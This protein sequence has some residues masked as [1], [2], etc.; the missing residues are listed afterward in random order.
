MIY[1]NLSEYL[2]KHLVHMQQLMML[3]TNSSEDAGFRSI[4]R[5]F[6]KF[7]KKKSLWCD[8]KPKK[9]EKKVESNQKVFRNKSEAIYEKQSLIDWT[10][11]KN[12]K[13]WTVTAT[14]R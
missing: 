13:L 9:R 14:S 5:K 11:K 8:L 10:K 1:N 6:F 3:S 12:K 4:T 7:D 2:L